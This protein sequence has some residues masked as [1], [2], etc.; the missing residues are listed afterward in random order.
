MN[1]K[2]FTLI[3]VLFSIAA[4]GIICAVLLKLFVLAGDTNKRA[5]DI[6]D[7]QVAVTSTVETLIGSG[8]VDDGLA[9]LGIY[10][11]DGSAAGQYTMVHDTYIV[12]LNISEKPGNYPG[13]L[14]ALSVKAEQDGRELASI[15]TARYDGG[16]ADG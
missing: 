14:Y 13:T 8:S 16:L 7:A 2:G 9:A 3:E 12:V 1:K 5:G 11:S 6:Q 4:L 15:E 10:P